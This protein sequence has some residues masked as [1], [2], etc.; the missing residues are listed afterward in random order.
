VAKSKMPPESGAAS[1][2]P[3]GDA[4]TDDG[5]PA[6]PEAAERLSEQM[7]S[8]GETYDTLSELMTS[9]S[10]TA[11]ESH[12]N[13]RG[14]GP[15]E[16][17]AVGDDPVT[18]ESQA[19]AT[20][21]VHDGGLPTP[22]SPLTGA[23][24]LAAGASSTGG[25][26]SLLPWAA[27]VVVGGIAGGVLGASGALGRPT[28]ESPAVEAA[29]VLTTPGYD[30]PGGAVVASFIPNQRVLA[31]ERSEDSAWL[32][33]RDPLNGLRTVWV[34][35]GVVDIDDGEAGIDSLALG[36]CPEPIIVLTAPEAVPPPAEPA[37]G[38]PVEPGAPG[39]PAPPAAPAPPS[40]PPP[41]S[42]TTPPS[43]G[44]ASFSKNPVYQLDPTVL[45][46]SAS[47]NTAVTGVTVTWSGA[48]QTGS[49]EMSAS[50][51]QWKYTFSAAN[52]PSGTI[53]FQ[54]KARDAAGNTSPAAQVNL[55]YIQFI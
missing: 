32:A 38:T 15:A 43:I 29:F 11:Q 10:R 48:Q 53:N 49:A 34:P 44:S 6:S 13:P 23:A 55:N 24:T 36:G 16:D 35:A 3:D 20:A 30:C 52:T 45:T 39:Q 41:P 25:A 4:P 2:P 9:G 47:D 40:P 27:L 54:V 1:E 18:G 26:A 50:G 22:A 7:R 42:D 31:R 28:T 37:P 17:D 8:E 33:V 14:T 46:V 19:E 5:N 51:S 12:Q 21:D